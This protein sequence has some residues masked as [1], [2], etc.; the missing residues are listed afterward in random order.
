MGH[1]RCPDVEP[2]PR[3]VG[4]PIGA[5]VQHATA[6]RPLPPVQ[7]G[8][9][10]PCAGELRGRRGSGGEQRHGALRVHPAREVPHAAGGEQRG[11]RER[12]SG[13]VGHERDGIPQPVR[14]REQ[15]GGPGGAR[16]GLVVEQSREEVR[17]QRREPDLAVA[18]RAHQC[19]TRRRRAMLPVGDRRK[20][21]LRRPSE[22]GMGRQARQ[23][24]VEVAA[25]RFDTALSQVG[26]SEV[27][28]ARSDPIQR[29]PARRHESHALADHALLADFQVD[30]V[31]RWLRQGYPHLAGEP[32][33][34]RVG[35]EPRRAD[36][37][38]SPVGHARPGG[39]RVEP[40]DRDTHQVAATVG[41][42][43]QDGGNGPKDGCRG[44][45]AGPPECRGEGSKPGDKAAS[46]SHV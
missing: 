41:L 46:V 18:D 22:I 6:I 34:A 4:V 39:G 17:E 42:P 43:I 24:R 28:M 9:R 31:R 3:P 13:H 32:G 40:G 45:R 1:L 16:Q 23:C 33:A 44:A 37:R 25:V 35:Q 11:E 30:L 19:V 20:R 7:L 5:P 21:A 14:A 2:E 15:A 29:P 36:Q 26:E 27:G 10:R 8:V 38:A 12:L